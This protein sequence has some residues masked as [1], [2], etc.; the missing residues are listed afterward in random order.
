MRKLSLRDASGL[1][2]LLGCARLG[3]NY[4][5]ATAVRLSALGLVEWEMT[6]MGFAVWLTANGKDEAL[7]LFESGTEGKWP[8]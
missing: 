1:V 5:K 3:A 4:G 7:R 6:P 2:Y 8:K